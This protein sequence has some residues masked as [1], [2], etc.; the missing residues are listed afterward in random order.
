MQTSPFLLHPTILS[1][2]LRHTIFFFPVNGD[3]QVAENR[4]RGMCECTKTNSEKS[5]TIDRGQVI[6]IQTLPY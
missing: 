2:L 4:R 1:R 3:Q 6:R 5:A